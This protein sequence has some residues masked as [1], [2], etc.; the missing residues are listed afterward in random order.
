MENVDIRDA[1]YDLV[2]EIY[3][4]DHD[5]NNASFFK[6]LRNKAIRKEKINEKYKICKSVECHMRNNPPTYDELSNFA[7]FVFAISKVFFYRNSKESIIY[8][9]KNNKFDK[10][11]IHFDV[12]LYE[13]KITVS[14]KRESGDEMVQIYI[15]RNYG[16]KLSNVHCVVNQI[17]PPDEDG[18]ETM[19]F[20]SVNRIVQQNM[21]DLYKEYVDKAMNGYI[22]D[23][24][25]KIGKKNKECYSGM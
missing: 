2:E 25:D 23:F 10:K 12:P 1:L 3:I 19:M 17:M 18:N 8:V 15:N 13:S 11:T 9:E 7:D 6:R 5:I 16:D 24:Y 22:Y 20:H 21:A 14:L 4:V